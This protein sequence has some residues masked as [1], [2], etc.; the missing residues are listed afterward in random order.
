[1]L[2]VFGFVIGTSPPTKGFEGSSRII[3]SSE[4]T[5]NIRVNFSTPTIVL[6]TETLRTELKAWHAETVRRDS[7]VNDLITSYKN[8]QREL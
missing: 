1:M 7:T 2:F 3:T 4:D 6:S 8:Y 5:V